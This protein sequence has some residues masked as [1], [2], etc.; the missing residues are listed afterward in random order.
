MSVR[1]I[2]G[3]FASAAIIAAP[4]VVHASAVIGSLG[5]FDVV[6]DTG[7]VAHGFEIDLEG[8]TLPQ[9]T[10]TFGGAGRGFP[11]TVER[12]GSPIVSEYTNGTTHGVS[13][14]YLADLSGSSSAWIGTPA[15]PMSPRVKAAGR[16]A[17]RVMAPPPLAT[18]SVS[19]P[20]QTRARPP[21]TGWWRVLRDHHR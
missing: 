4:G 5:N 2:L 21:M 15:A 14:V 3:L 17:G 18:T 16:A 11:T 6:N 8:L 13:V 19:A 20:L 12:Y 10:D 1:K 7:S 9:V